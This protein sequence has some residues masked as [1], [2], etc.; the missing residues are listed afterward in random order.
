MKDNQINGNWQLTNVYCFCGF[1]PEIN[2]N[3]YTLSFAESSNMVTLYNP[4]EG[5]FYIAETG[6]YSYTL[7]DNKILK[8]AGAPVFK[9]TIENDILT[10]VLVDN[11]QIADDELT[12]VYK[13]T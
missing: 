12:L 4:T 7:I 13:R 2:F 3:D 11:P 10:L 6:S 5:Y 8:I 1:D 9:Y